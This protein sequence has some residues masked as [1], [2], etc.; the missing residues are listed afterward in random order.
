MRNNNILQIGITES[1][2]I[3]EHVAD[4]THTHIASYLFI[5]EHYFQCIFILLRLPWFVIYPQRPKKIE[6]TKG[7]NS[8][9]L[10]GYKKVA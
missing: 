9:W 10:W 5:D 2:L 1:D 8:Q 3:N 4:D 6:H 7:A